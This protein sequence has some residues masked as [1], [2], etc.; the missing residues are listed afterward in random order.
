[1]PQALYQCLLTALNFSF[2]SILSSED[3]LFSNKVS[4]IFKRKFITFYPVFPPALYK[5]FQDIL[6]L[7]FMKN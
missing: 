2:H 5:K 1:M 7:N 3:F 4:N 6:T